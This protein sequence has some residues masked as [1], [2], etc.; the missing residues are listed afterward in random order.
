MKSHVARLK[1]T[2]IVR[3][4]L[5]AALLAKRL[6]SVVGNSFRLKFERVIHYRRLPNRE[7][8]DQQSLIDSTHLLPRESVRIKRQMQKCGTGLIQNQT[9][10]I[11]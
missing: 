1:V 4:E 9:L 10:Q 11:S 8:Y 6:R 5:S 2:T 7:S 3:L